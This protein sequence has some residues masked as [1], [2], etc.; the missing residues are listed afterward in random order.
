M[1]S[2]FPYIH[3][4]KSLNQ[5]RE[6]STKDAYVI[7]NSIQCSLILMA[8]IEIPHSSIHSV[9]IYFALAM[10][11]EYHSRPWGYHSKQW[12]RSFLSWSWL[13]F[14]WRQ[15]DNEQASRQNNSTYVICR[16]KIPKG[17]DMCDLVASLDWVVIKG[18]LKELTYKLRFDGREKRAK[19]KS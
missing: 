4:V 9:N 11:Q 16:Q 8:R 18:K 6:L 14:Y 7:I 17:C 12:M 15:I 10:C 19:R 13:T 1:T 5:F 2:N 3:W